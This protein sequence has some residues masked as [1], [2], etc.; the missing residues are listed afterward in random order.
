MRR[1]TECIVCG[2]TVFLSQFSKKSGAGDEFTLVKCRNCGLN[3]LS[4]VPDPVE[5]SKYYEREYFTKRTDRGYN[6][7]FSLELKDEIERVFKLNLS[8]LGFYEFEK[9]LTNGKFSLDIGCAAG[10]FVH[11]LKNRG[12]NAKGIDISRECVEHAREQ[13]LDVLQADYLDIDFI[14]KFDLITL[15]A[16]IEHLHDPGLVLDKIY[17][18]LKKDGMLY[19]STCRADGMNFMRLF[20][21]RWRFYN[22]PEHIYFFSYNTI[23]RLLSRHGF[24]LLH[25]RTYGSN[26]GNSGTF[27]R[28]T[29]DF[30]AKKLFWGDM[31]ILAARKI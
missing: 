10:Y 15:W 6:N 28:K 30:L 12:W 7:Y 24:R 16:T 19:I 29:A 2:S 27:V 8:D 18:D 31:M 3:F 1:I 23:K 20:G 11:Y 22:F 17:N 5:I 25:Y 13:Q 26:F 21:E 9:S 14:E 4:E